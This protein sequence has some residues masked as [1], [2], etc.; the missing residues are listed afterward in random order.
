MVHVKNLARWAQPF[1][2]SNDRIRN[3]LENLLP[4]CHSNEK[5]LEDHTAEKTA[6]M[7]DPAVTD[8]TGE[9]KIDDDAKSTKSGPKSQP[10]SKQPSRAGSAQSGKSGK[11]S[12][13]PAMA[14]TPAGSVRGDNP[15]ADW[16]QMRRIIAEDPAYSLATVPLLVDLCIKHIVT[17]FDNNST[18]LNDLP[19]RYKSKVL[20]KIS[21]DIPLKI[22]ANLVQEEDYW[23]RCCKARWEI[24]DVSQYGGNWKRICPA[25]TSPVREAPKGPDFDD[26]SDAGS[27]AGDEPECDHFNFAPVL[28]CLTNLEELHL[29]YGVS[30]CG[31]NFEWNL[32][33][34]TAR[35]CLQL[36]QCVAAC[37]HL[38]VF[39]LS[40]STLDDDKTRVLISHILDHPSLT[41]LDLSHNTISDRGARAI[42][43]FLNNRSQLVSL[44]LCD[45]D[46]KVLGAQAIAHALTK[47]TT[48]QNLNLRLN[49]LG[50]E[51]ASAISRALQ[52]NS[53]LQKINL[54]SNEFGEATAPFLQ[55]VIMQNTTLK[56][57]D[58]SCN[59]LGPEGGK[60]IQEGMEVNT[61]VTH[62]DLRITDCGQEAEYCIQQI[63]H[64]NKETERQSKIQ[65]NS[66]RIWKRLPPQ[67]AH[68]FKPEVPTITVQ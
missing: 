21:T 56:S 10:G 50:D 3:S 33:K 7:S 62:M 40:R 43:K 51:G 65:D 9:D 23:N 6:K 13:R 46:I 58:L 34:F 18:I 68:R 37:K 20:D 5:L 59:K 36:A 26:A 52:R 39:H 2:F 32:F 57:M 47:N 67:A 24:C 1:C 15:A 49:R 41:T 22:T 25:V 64:R 17:H 42:G 54:G 29:T 38:K 14:A 55:E 30:D 53:T 28:K 19:P 60:Q 35:D 31:M 27:D 45:N 48:L 11:S 16:R 63:L 12:G 4:D 44:N 61:T 8:G 66:G